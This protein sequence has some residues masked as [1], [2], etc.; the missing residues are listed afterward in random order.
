MI[1]QR[2]FRSCVSS[3]PDGIYLVPVIKSGTAN[4]FISVSSPFFAA[5]SNPIKIICDEVE[6][7]VRRFEFSLFSVEN[8]R[9]GDLKGIFVGIYRV[10]VR[11]P[12]WFRMIDE[13]ATYEYAVTFVLDEMELGIGRYFILL[14]NIAPYEELSYGILDFAGCHRINFLIVPNG[15]SLRHP[16]LTAY[17]MRY[18][19]PDD[20]EYYDY[21]KRLN[22]VMTVS[23]SPIYELEIGLDSVPDTYVDKYDM[24]IFD[25]GLLLVTKIPDMIHKPTE[26]I[27]FAAPYGLARGTVHIVI[28]HNGIP[29][30]HFHCRRIR[31]LGKLKVETVAKESIFWYL[32]KNKSL[33][34]YGSLK[35]KILPVLKNPDILP[36]C[37]CIIDEISSCDVILDY[38]LEDLYPRKT[39]IKVY[40]SDKNLAEKI[41]NLNIPDGSGVVVLDLNYTSESL[42]NG[43]CKCIEEFVR[44]GKV[45]AIIYGSSR[46]VSSF[47]SR[48]DS[49]SRLI[50][51]ENR[52]HTGPVSDMEKVYITINEMSSNCHFINNDLAEELYDKFVNHRG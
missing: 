48:S 51:A 26:K 46:K 1:K 5:V 36:D 49:M 38:I 32:H 43:W 28:Y 37:L 8:T 22:H 42:W 41:T 30:F 40:D 50:P 7:S 52:W 39:Y 31:R 13:E 11:N 21:Y 19:D 27:R 12:I 35:N 44:N 10:G 47:F 29:L 9:Y 24:G 34:I 4:R 17:D 2:H 25:E 18:I 14:G 3:G 20:K 45:K 6:S 15:K 16:A 33:Q 23:D